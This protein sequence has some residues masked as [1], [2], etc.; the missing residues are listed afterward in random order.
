MLYPLLNS[1]ICFNSFYVD[2][3]GFSI[4]RSC[5]LHTIKILPLPLQ[6][7]YIMFIFLRHAG[8]GHTSLICG[9]SRKAFSFPQLSIILTMCL[10]LKKIKFIYFNWRLIILQYCIGFAIHQ[11]ESTMGIHVFPILNLPPFSLLV[12]SPWVIPVHQP[13]ASYI[14]HLTWTSDSFHI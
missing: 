2:S 1:F 7:G 13:Q 8:N 14:M 10:S 5:H 9:L 11:H 3:L 4:H 6:F 12:P